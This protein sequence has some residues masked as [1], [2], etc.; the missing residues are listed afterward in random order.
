MV[1]NWC[2]SL[3]YLRCLSIGAP[4]RKDHA[5]SHNAVVDDSFP[6]AKKAEGSSLQV[7]VTLEETNSLSGLT[8][9]DT[10]VAR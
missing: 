5:K 1:T 10:E 4:C 6:D 8:M 3:D 7:Y 9:L 2:L